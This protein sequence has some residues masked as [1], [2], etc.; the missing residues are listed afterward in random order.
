MPR[1]RCDAVPAMILRASSFAK[2]PRTSPAASPAFLYSLARSSI[3]PGKF[4][5]PVLQDFVGDF[6]LI[7]GHNFFDRAHA[8]L[9]VLAHRQQ[10]VNHNRRPRQRLQHAHLPALNALGNFHFA[11]ARKQRHRPHLAQIHADGVVGLFHRSGGEIEF[12][13]LAF[14]DFI[15]FFIERGRREFR[16]FEHIDTLRTDR[17]QQIVEVLGAVHIVRDQ[18]VDLIVGEIAFLFTC[19]DQLFN[20]VVLVFKSQEGLSSNSSIR[21]RGTWITCS[22]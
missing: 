4:V 6:F 10:F 13:I 2:P 9:Q 8:L 7:E 1:A 20:I 16:A 3:L 15:E 14:F 21:P 17:S 18:V 5:Q 11:F 22:L 19:I 12:N